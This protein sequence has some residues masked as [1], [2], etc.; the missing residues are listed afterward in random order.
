MSIVC[1]DPEEFCKGRNTRRF[2]AAFL[3]LVFSFFIISFV[4]SPSIPRCHK[5]TNI[6]PYMMASWILEMP[7]LLSPDQVDLATF[8]FRLVVN[9]HRAS[10]AC[11]RLDWFVEAGL[12]CGDSSLTGWLSLTWSFSLEILIHDSLAGWLDLPRRILRSVPVT[13]WHISGPR[14]PPLCFLFSCTLYHHL[15]E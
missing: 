15:F 4:P 7:G 1:H 12:H 10:W 5:C 8:T 11:P 2:S 6:S 13:T 3:R 14:L 9:R